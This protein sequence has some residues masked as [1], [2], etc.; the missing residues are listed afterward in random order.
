MADPEAL[1]EYFRLKS[2]FEQQARGPHGQKKCVQCK[3]PSTQGTVFVTVVHEATDRSESIRELKASCGFLSDPCPLKLSVRVPKTES[4]FDILTDLEAQIEQTKRAILN[5]KNRLLFGY[6]TDEQALTRFTEQKDLLEGFTL[7]HQ[8][9]LDVFHS[10]VSNPETEAK[11]QQT[12]VS[13]YECISQI[14]EHIRQN[15]FEEAA[16]LY[17]KEGAEL[18]RKVRELTYEVNRVVVSGDSSGESHLIQQP[19]RANRLNYCFEAL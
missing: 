18:C 13:L 3:R 1:R 16:L 10:I 5:D 4:L 7:L 12:I 8:K 6:I 11:Q 17:V 14:K 15:A 2:S 19:I 9:Y